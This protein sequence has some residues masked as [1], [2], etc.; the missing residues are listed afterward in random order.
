MRL[1][2]QKCC[3]L[4]QFLV[5]YSLNFLS[6]WNH[7][8]PRALLCIRHIG[9]E[10]ISRPNFSWWL[11][12][13]NILLRE[14]LGWGAREVWYSYLRVEKGVFTWNLASFPVKCPFVAV[15]E[16]VSHR[17]AAKSWRD[18]CYTFL[19]VLDDLNAWKWSVWA[20][21]SPCKGVK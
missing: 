4:F 12:V 7:D 6:R 18:M 13:T 14:S 10:M 11:V 2:V 3:L 21:I 8:K 9:Q 16:D 19:L 20:Q 17:R 1:L 5:S 15:E